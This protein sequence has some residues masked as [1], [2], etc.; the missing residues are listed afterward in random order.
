LPDLFVKVNNL[1]S[2]FARLV[3]L[4]LI[5]RNSSRK[6]LAAEALQFGITISFPRY[7]NPLEYWVLYLLVL[8][9]SV[10]LGVYVSAVGYDLAVNH[11]LSATQDME[12]T[13]RWMIYATANYGVAI[14]VILLLRLALNRFGDGVPMSHLITYC[15]TFLVAFVVGPIGLGVALKFL[16]PTLHDTHLLVIIGE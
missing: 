13:V 8:L 4:Y 10:Y 1:H 12:R 6:A 5:Y 15:W 3:A 9:G 16:A 7:E 11:A 2:R 14:I